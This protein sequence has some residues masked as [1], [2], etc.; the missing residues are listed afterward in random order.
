MPSPVTTF[1]DFNLPNPTTWLIFSF[2]LAVA[3]FFKFSRL[4]SVRNLDV[5]MIFLLAPGLLLVQA[6]RPQ[7]VAAERNPATHITVLVGHAS[8]AETAPEM[9]VNAAHFTQESSQ[10]LEN[11]RWLWW[12][13]FWLLVGSVYFFCRCLLDLPLVQRPALT[14]NLQIGGL[15]W[16][17]GALLICLLAV[18]YRQVERYINPIAATNGNAPFL[19]M[20]PPTQSVFAVAI[21]WQEWPAWAVAALAFGGHCLVVVLLVL[22]GW[23]HFQD[24]AAGMAAATFYLLLPYTGVSVGQLHHVLPMA[25]FL[26]TLLTFRYPIA[27]GC[28]LGVATAATYFPL[29]ILPIYV[30]FYRQRGV[31]R[32]LVSFAAV[33]ALGLIYLG[34]MLSSEAKF[35]E[36]WELTMKSPGWQPW[37]RDPKLEG[38]WSGVHWAYRIP[39]FLLF[40]IFVLGTTFWPTPKNLAHV[41]ALS[42][43]VFIAVQWWCAD[44]GG[45]YILWYLPLLLLLIFRPNLQDRMPPLIQPE[46]DWLTRSLHWLAATGRRF[47]PLPAREKTGAT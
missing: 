14:A 16:L 32:F 39:V 23:R 46:T 13:Y 2:L 10:A 12:G 40:L 9:I 42:A 19:L 45:V 17:A 35:E 18:A 3:L 38:F 34:L 21:L 30:S 5:V 36:S 15:A 41:I 27:T 28:L 31:G 6:T 26:G 47:L 11:V 37:A 29:F 24:L 25:L 44:Q 1:L 33:L 8:T 4:L 20:H 43:A 22:I 7:P